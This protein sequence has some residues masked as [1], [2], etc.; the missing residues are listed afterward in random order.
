MIMRSNDV[1]WALFNSNNVLIAQFTQSRKVGF[2]NLSK[3]IDSSIMLIANYCFLFALCI[4]CG[5]NFFKPKLSLN[6]IY[7]YISDVDVEN[8]II[9][10]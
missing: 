7:K 8:F 9:D 6:T 4:S 1:A 2:L 3:V 10:R 5:F